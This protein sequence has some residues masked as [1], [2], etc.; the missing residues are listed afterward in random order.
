MGV[1][2]SAPNK[3]KIS[4]DGG[5]GFLAYGASGMQGW[6]TGMEDAHITNENLETQT[7]L[8]AVFDGHGGPE[9]AQFSSRHFG[10]LLLKQA[11]YK[12]G[13]YGEG[14]RQA[15]LGIDTLLRTEDGIAEIKAQKQEDMKDEG[16]SL[17][18]LFS[19]EYNE[20]GQ[21]RINAGC[22]ANVALLKDNKIFVANAGD[23]RAVL[24]RNG[25]AVAL[26]QDHKPELQG[27]LDRIRKAGGT[28]TDGRVNGNL[29]LSRSLGDLEY[30]KD[31][32]IPP[33]AQLISANPDLEVVDLAPD[34]DFL[35]LA[36]DGVWD[37]MSN[38]QAV[39]FVS[40]KLKQDPNVR[41]SSICEDIF[42]FC[43]APTTAQ[44]IGCDNMTC[45]IIKFNH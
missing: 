15:F 13:D 24:S 4:N 36:C 3:E 12:S 28:V 34:C 45:I 1:Y 31:N 22:T 21:Y 11:P 33:E 38:Q 40:Q 25:L 20:E 42:E 14:L 35:I 39:D 23:S 37:V 27:E 2:L 19:S 5:D 26:S 17:G 30:K 29:N 9:V 44:G 18:M 32:T 6:R 7:A 41:I 16:K 8:F 43:C 10:E